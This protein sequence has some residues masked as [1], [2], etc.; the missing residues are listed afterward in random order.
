[1][2]RK[3]VLGK[4]WV[5]LNQEIPKHLRRFLE[6]SLPEI[7]SAEG[8]RTLVLKKVESAKRELR[9]DATIQDLPLDTLLEV[10]LAN[11]HRLDD[12]SK[13]ARIDF[14]LL[15]DIRNRYA[16]ASESFFEN[17]D[18]HLR[19]AIDMARC[20]AESIGAYDELA[21]TFEEI[22]ADID[23]LLSQP[24]ERA[25]QGEMPAKHADSQD[26]IRRFVEA[27]LID[28]QEILG[29]H[30][31]FVG[32]EHVLKKVETFLNEQSRGTLL[33]VGDPGIGKTR[34]MVHLF[35]KVLS[36]DDPPP[37]CFFYR[38]A[39]DRTD[40]DR[41]I[42]HLFASL[43]KSHGVPEKFELPE[44]GDPAPESLFNAFDGYLTDHLGKRLGPG[45]R[46]V[47]LID[48][49]D[50]ASPT[51]RAFQRLP[52]GCC[53]IATTR[54]VEERQLF[55]ARRDDVEWCNLHSLDWANENR[56]DG[57]QYVEQTL[58][59]RRLSPETL[60]E[61]SRSGDGNF[62]VLQMACR[63][64][65]DHLQPDEVPEFLRRLATET[66]PD[67][68]RLGFLYEV[69]FWKR[70]CDPDRFSADDASLVHHV[71]AVLVAA[72]TPITKTFLCEC[73]GL[74]T[75]ECDRGLRHLLQYVVPPFNADDETRYR[76]YHESF[77]DFLRTRIKRELKEAEL[78]LGDLCV[79]WGDLDGTTRQYALRF[80]PERLCASERWHELAGL[81]TD[82][83]FIKAKCEA[84]M[85]SDLIQDYVLASQR[86]PA[87]KAV[88]AAAQRERKLAEWIKKLQDYSRVWRDCFDRTRKGEENVK[89]PTMRFPKPLDS[90]DV[91]A[92]I[93]RA[94]ADTQAAVIDSPDGE[95]LLLR[96]CQAFVNASRHE[97]AQSKDWLVPLAYN[98]TGIQSFAEQVD[99]LAKD[100]TGRV[101]AADLQ[102]PQGWQMGARVA[103]LV[104]H[105]DIVTHLA[106]TPD[107]KRGVTA[108]RDKT[109]RLWNL[110]TGE[111]LAEAEIEHE[112][113]ITSLAIASDGLR[114]VTGASDGTLCAWQVNL[115]DREPLRLQ[116]RFQEHT[117]SVTC[118]WCSPDG[119]LA[120]SQSM[121]DG[122][123]AIWDFVAGECLGHGVH[124]EL[125]DTEEEQELESVEE[126]TEDT[127]TTEESTTLKQMLLNALK[128]CDYY[129]NQYQSADGGVTVEWSGE[130][131]SLL[132]VNDG[133]T[134]KRLRE[135]PLGVLVYDY[136]PIALTADGR[137][138]WIGHDRSVEA[139]DLTSP[140]TYDWA[141]TAFA[142]PSRISSA[143]GWPADGTLRRTDSCETIRLSV[144]K[145]RQ[146][147]E[148]ER[149]IKGVS[150]GEQP[151]LG[152]TQDP[153]KKV[154]HYEWFGGATADRSVELYL[155]CYPHGWVL[156]ARHRRSQIPLRR[157]QHEAIESP[158]KCF[159]TPNG[160]S[161]IVKRAEGYHCGRCDDASAPDLVQHEKGY[162][163]YD[164]PSGTV[165]GNVAF[166][167]VLRD[168]RFEQIETASCGFNS[169][170]EKDLD[171]PDRTISIDI[172][173]AT[174]TFNA[175]DEHRQLR[176][177]VRDLAETNLNIDFITG[178]AGEIGNIEPSVMRITPDGD[179]LIVL[180]VEPDYLVDSIRAL[181]I[182]SGSC[183]R[184]LL[185]DEDDH[186][187]S[188]YDPLDQYYEWE[189]IVTPDGRFVAFCNS[190]HQIVLKSIATG[191]CVGT[192]RG[193]EAAVWSMAFT[194]DS[195]FLISSSE[196]QTLRVW[197]LDL[198][199]GSGSGECLACQPHPTIALRWVDLC[200]TVFNKYNEPQVH[201]RNLPQIVAPVTAAR[202]FR[203]QIDPDRLAKAQQT[204]RPAYEGE[205]I[206][207]KFDDEPT[208]ECPNCHKRDYVPPKIVR[209]IEE[210]FGNT[211]PPWCLNL[212][213]KAWDDPRLQSPCPNPNCHWPLR[214]Y[215]FIA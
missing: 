186:D 37:V 66:M 201:V 107:G 41:C 174:M 132:N 96:T 43:L 206:P 25:R 87:W 83:R 44:F 100:D 197:K 85:L 31:D 202:I 203:Y 68:D 156:E 88:N 128:G 198:G 19:R 111:Q 26:A 175:A 47:I 141:E 61:I 179:V 3:Q 164:I 51:E 77:A 119:S 152:D 76:I 23:G 171:L 99:V 208:A 104:G 105:N 157:L 129:T 181:R 205:S 106:I 145:L 166:D 170:R 33:L 190:D 182:T 9:K 185:L 1:M 168:N 89:L 42:R 133:A 177:R 134:G 69:E 27:N 149:E 213:S 173:G 184:S 64:V 56:R 120:W 138:A 60:Q 55:L 72:R 65:R 94:D 16:H 176:R 144:E 199:S 116:H 45:Q 131:R 126:D 147:H 160:L 101:W 200:G 188:Y 39:D 82:L 153:C 10:I 4:V 86:L 80:G 62:L 158:R 110:T 183:E 189:P 78:K 46:Q 139:F 165:V 74:R 117:A 11:S 215:P 113:E 40:P 121:E 28:F 93:A 193:H 196:D 195:R 118:I 148:W 14:R 24:G 112:G 161:A 140:W 142:G 167:F 29:E 92:E 191:D 180:A 63:H 53:V 84:G 34:L 159:L 151:L 97:L 178:R 115:S 122:T 38:R 57:H 81:L 204:G 169:L 73:L 155:M 48:G 102:R 98:F 6:T 207:G 20:V 18:R 30:S 124:S 146:W 58:A 91:K 75:A 136:P 13:D 214:Y 130:E 172:G 194:P 103:T 137:I 192:L 17:P 211:Q 52:H 154:P 5:F 187:R 50:E 114:V 15:K 95:L 90:S 67:G 59:D 108:S 8:F 2:S 36:D 143:H 135:Y 21:S 32:R 123:S 54:G 7:K 163:I 150:S 212:P 210:L 109:I 35:R 70:L 71:A 12:I 22:D 162:A 209:V 79:R 127:E 125:A 49:L